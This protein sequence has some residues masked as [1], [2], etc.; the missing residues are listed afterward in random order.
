MC[1]EAVGLRPPDTDI[2]P[3]PGGAVG[4]VMN[5]AEMLAEDQQNWCKSL[6]TLEQSIHTPSHFII[7]LSDTHAHAHAHIDTC[8]RAHLH[9][10]TYTQAHTHLHTLY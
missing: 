10:H 9:T 2:S 8:A 3:L 6:T 1:E 5:S 7:T 4:E